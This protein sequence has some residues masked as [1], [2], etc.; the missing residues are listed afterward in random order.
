MRLSYRRD[1]LLVLRCPSKCLSI[2]AAASAATFCC[3]LWVGGGSKRFSMNTSPYLH[4]MVSCCSILSLVAEGRAAA[5]NKQQPSASFLRLLCE[6]FDPLAPPQ[7][8]DNRDN[9][10]LTTTL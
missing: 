5:T 8:R 1:W 7:I 3:H 6:I 2:A 9:G 4:S 10:R